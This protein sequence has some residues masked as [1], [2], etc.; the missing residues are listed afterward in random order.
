M[1]QTKVSVKGDMEDRMFD[2]WPKHTI[3]ETWKKVPE[4]GKTLRH[5]V[6]KDDVTTC[7]SHV[8]LCFSHGNPGW[9]KKGMIIQEAS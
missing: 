2:Q 9:H 8:F 3:K 5:S 6:S 4:I 7:I 1:K